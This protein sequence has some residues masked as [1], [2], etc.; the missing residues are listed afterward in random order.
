MYV[1]WKIQWP[2]LKSH[3]QWLKQRNLERKIVLEIQTLE[4]NFQNVQFDLGLHEKIVF[5]QW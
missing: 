3:T 5:K 1:V 2:F 4:L